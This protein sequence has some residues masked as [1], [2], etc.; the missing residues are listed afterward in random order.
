MNNIQVTLQAS[1]ITRL[2]DRVFLSYIKQNVRLLLTM[3][4]VSAYKETGY[5]SCF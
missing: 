5:F 3:G 4:F 1:V 2:H